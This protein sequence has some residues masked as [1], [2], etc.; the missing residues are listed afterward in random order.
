M[1]QNLWYL[2][3]IFK[4]CLQLNKSHQ[5]R[6]HQIKSFGYS[7]PFWMKIFNTNKRSTNPNRMFGYIYTK[8]FY[9]RIQ[10]TFKFFTL[11]RIR[12]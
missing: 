3:I 11:V 1:Y 10:C 4:Y 12:L 2:Y 8:Q 9:Y 5:N 6:S 7:F